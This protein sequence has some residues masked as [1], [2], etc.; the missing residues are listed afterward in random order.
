MEPGTG[1]GESGSAPVLIGNGARLALGGR[2][3]RKRRW[4]AWGSWHRVRGLGMEIGGREGGAVSVRSGEDDG[5]G[6]WME[7]EGGWRWTRGRLG[8]EAAAAVR[9][10]G[11]WARRAR[12]AKEAEGKPARTWRMALGGRRSQAVEGENKNS[13]YPRFYLTYT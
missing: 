3:R 4:A 1:P 2:R 12:V 9:I 7:I 11:G 10:E 8:S 5:A 6:T 13:E